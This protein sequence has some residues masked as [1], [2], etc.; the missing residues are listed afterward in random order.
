LQSANAQ[1]RGEIEERRRTEAIIRVHRDLGLTLSGKVGYKKPCGYAWE[2]AI[3]ISA[4]TAVECMWSIRFRGP[5]P[6]LSPGPLPEFVQRVAHYEADD[7]NTYLV[8]AGRPLYAPLQDLPGILD[9]RTL[10]KVC[11]RWRSFR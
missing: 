8:M 7:L 4:W 5:G 10:R 3:T 6:G 11:A 1:L 9:E 2:T